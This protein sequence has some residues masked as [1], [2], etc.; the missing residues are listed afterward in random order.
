M[1]NNLK[2]KKGYSA[3]GNFR[4]YLENE[5]PISRVFTQ[6]LKSDESRYCWSLWHKKKVSTLPFHTSGSRVCRLIIKCVVIWLC[7]AQ[8]RTPGNW[9]SPRN[10]GHHSSVY[11]VLL[12]SSGKRKQA[13]LLCC[14]YYSFP[15]GK[16]TFKSLWLITRKEHFIFC[17]FDRLF[18]SWRKFPNECLSKG[19]T[20]L[21]ENS[22]CRPCALVPTV[23]SEN[24]V[25]PAWHGGW[26]FQACVVSCL[27]S[28]TLL[29]L[30]QW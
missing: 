21:I 24:S 20:I 7:V 30:S 29:V 14:I 17:D 23:V 13:G 4:K 6:G 2:T 22:S 10:P 5:W 1:L 15:K 27:L 12:R 18:C 19:K 8:V 9:W 28:Q 26:I 11:M 16:K 3:H 25:M